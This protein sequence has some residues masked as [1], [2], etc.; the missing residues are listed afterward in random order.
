[1]NNEEI[2]LGVTLVGIEDETQ[3]AERLVELLKEAKTLADELASMDF[4]IKLDSTI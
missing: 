3:K 4:E 2:K 1:M